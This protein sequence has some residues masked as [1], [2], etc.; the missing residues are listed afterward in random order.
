MIQ[1]VVAT[2][3]VGH[4]AGKLAEE[5]KTLASGTLSNV[6]GYKE[7][8]RI[9]GLQNKFESFVKDNPFSQ[10]LEGK[11]WMDMWKSFDIVHNP[12]YGFG[13]KINEANPTPSSI[14]SGIQ[15]PDAEV[16]GDTAIDITSSIKELYA[17]SEW[18]GKVS[19]VYVDLGSS[20]YG[21]HTEITAKEDGK[22]SETSD[23]YFTEIAGKL[24]LGL[25]NGK[26]APDHGDVPID[27]LFN[28]ELQG[29]IIE[30]IHQ[31]REMNEQK[32]I[33]ISTAV[34]NLNDH[35]IILTPKENDFIIKILESNDDG[36]KNITE[37]L[38]DN[39]IALSSSEI[40][41]LTGEK[42]E[43]S[44]EILDALEEK[45]I[46][47]KAEDESYEVSNVFLHKMEE[48]GNDRIDFKYLSLIDKA[49]VQKT[50]KETET[51][52]VEAQKA[53]KTDKGGGK[54]IKPVLKPE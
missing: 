34:D 31:K 1:K 24:Y 47:N 46:L 52:V 21:L 25:E 44:T 16:L 49:E 32:E 12:L 20:V 9:D 48:D 28:P 42:E 22:P 36:H 40:S 33:E 3:V 19:E 45:G 5:I 41:D 54:G 43:K 35:P 11:N 6:S 50:I 13:K 10:K 8:D 18:K 27:T 15:T 37:L 4:L 17:N 29:R 30:A 39:N 14:E 53:Q 51:K 26:E 7:N 2:A 38:S 23:F